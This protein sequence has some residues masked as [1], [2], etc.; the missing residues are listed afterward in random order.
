MTESWELDGEEAKGRWQQRNNICKNVMGK[1][2]GEDSHVRGRVGV[3]TMP[4]SSRNP[5]SCTGIH[6][7]PSFGTPSFAHVSGIYSFTFCS[8]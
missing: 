6:S 4:T 7:L 2:G 8:C 1:T 3:G 5:K